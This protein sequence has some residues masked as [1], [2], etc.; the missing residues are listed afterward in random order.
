M[1]Y[2]PTKFS[3]IED[4]EKFVAQFKKFVEADFDLNKFPK[5]FYTQLS[6]SFGH[7]AHYNQVGFYEEFFLDSY[8]KTR[9]LKQTLNYP[10]YG[11]P[12]YTF[13]DAEREIQNW[14]KS[15]DIVGLNS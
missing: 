2:T 10:C 8:G 11:L 15:L 12:D 1:K 3:T 4:K 5:W 6:M 7:I 13:C 14:L 9:F